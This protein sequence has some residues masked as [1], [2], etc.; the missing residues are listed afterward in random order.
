M[1]RH[2]GFDVWKVP[3]SIQEVLQIAKNE[4][5][6]LY[7]VMPLDSEVNFYAS[8]RLR[9]QIQSAFPRAI[10]IQTTGM[11]G[12][13]LRQIKAKS[14]IF[15]CLMIVGIW[16]CLQHIIWEYEIIGQGKDMQQR[17][18]REL[19]KFPV[20]FWSFSSKSE[21]IQQHLQN[22]FVNELSWLDVYEEGG[23]MRLMFSRR[24]QAVFEGLLSEPLY[25]TKHAMVAYFEIQHGN[26][27]V[28]EYD[29]VKE[30]TLLV[31]AVLLDSQNVPQ[32]VF[33]KGRVFGY[34]WYTIESQMSVKD[35]LHEGISFY[36]L[37]FDCRNQISKY[38][39]QDE[40]FIKETILQYSQNEGTILLQVHYTLLEDI[41]LP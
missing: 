35:S 22:V 20:P 17:I 8:C 13:V 21:S 14:F 6:H 1:N 4:K 38:L 36:R 30:G 33:V 37:L 7:E 24:K 12:L 26:K 29:F 9:K 27:L 25:A 16:F 11:F 32:S 15:S 40:Q 34:T 23:R 18:A 10:L 3:W 19:E 31:D 5:L 2:T 28:R 41:T 39:S